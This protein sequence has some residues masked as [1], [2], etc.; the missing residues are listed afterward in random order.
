MLR[1]RVITAVF[2]LAGFIGVLFVFPDWVA[3]FVFACVA[4]LAAWDKDAAPES[5]QD[6]GRIDLVKFYSHRGQVY[7]REMSMLELKAFQQ[8]WAVRRTQG[9]WLKAWKEAKGVAVSPV[10]P[11]E[12]PARYIGP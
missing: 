3:S 9:I 10:V 6:D 4:A 11:G 7:G 1:T 2:L 5:P 8:A 12:P